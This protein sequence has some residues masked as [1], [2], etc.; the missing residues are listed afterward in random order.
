METRFRQDTN[1]DEGVTTAIVHGNPICGRA[2]SGH[3]LWFDKVAPRRKTLTNWRASD[4]LAGKRLTLHG[5]QEC[6][7]AAFHG[8]PK[9]ARKATPSG[10][11]RPAARLA[12]PIQE[13]PERVGSQRNRAMG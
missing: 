9:Q 13:T 4:R 6:N 12:P 10:F 8:A 11:R 5:K 7:T 2:L 3:A 1:D